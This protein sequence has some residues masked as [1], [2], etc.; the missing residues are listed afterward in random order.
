MDHAPCLSACQRAPALSSSVSLTPPACPSISGFVTL[1]VWLSSVFAFFFFVYFCYRITTATKI[2]SGGW[3]W[4]S[5]GCRRVNIFFFLTRFVMLMQSRGCRGVCLRMY[6]GSG[7]V[8]GCMH[9]CVP[10]IGTGSLNP[11]G[12]GWGGGVAHVAKTQNNLCYVLNVTMVIYGRHH[13]A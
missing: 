10:G 13:S 4:W 12:W 1:S 11:Q 2:P 8:C 7:G 6:D 5:G 9:V 3:W